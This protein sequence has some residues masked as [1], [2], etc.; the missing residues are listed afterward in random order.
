MHNSHKNWPK[1]AQLIQKKFKVRWVK[2]E[3]ENMDPNGPPLWEASTLAK[4]YSNSL[5]LAIQN[6]T[7]A[8]D[9]PK[10]NEKDSALH[11]MNWY[12][13][14]DEYKLDRIRIKQK[15]FRGNAIW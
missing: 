12:R 9:R 13:R 2:E 7:W 6:S 5:L 10:K 14:E 3:K 1:W 11:N 8:Y 15:I 4:S